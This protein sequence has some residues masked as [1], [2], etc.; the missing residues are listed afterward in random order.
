MLMLLVAIL[1]FG[2]VIFV[3]ELGHFAIAKWSG[4]KVNE[5]AIGMGP[6]LLKFQK[7][8]TVYAL[9]LLPIGGFVSMEGEDEES[10]DERSYTS[11][12]VRKRFMVIIAGAFMNLVLGFAAM[13]LLVACSEG[14]LLVSRT[15]ATFYPEASTQDT[16][17]AVG[18]TIVEVNGRYCFV[19]D[20][21]FYEFARTQ[22][23][24]VDLTVLRDGEKIE[25][26]NVVFATEEYMDEQTGESHLLMVV[27]FKVLG[28]PKGFFSVM[29]ESFLKT[30][31]CVRLI[32]LSLLDLV[33]GNVAVNQLSGPVGI[34]NE[35]GKAASIGW[36]PV[37][38][39]LAMISVNL[40][41]MNMLPLPALDGSK[42]LLLIVEGIRRKPINHNLEIGISIAGFALLMC[43]MVFVSFNDIRKIF[44]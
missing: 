39:M 6:R 38:N 8:E 31:S 44:F 35:I 36:R 40:G 16:G 4:I 22:D 10:F 9:R 11:A 7:G 3:H 14:D 34:V 19:I 17:L 26:Q 43:L 5:F 24:T 32:Y 30:V 27:D 25:L 1:V 18:D 42:A 28:V 21:V 37:V 12:P 23:A 15:I 20:D 29:K 2:A 41:V 33:T 13:L